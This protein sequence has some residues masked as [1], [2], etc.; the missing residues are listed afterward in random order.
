MPRLHQHF[1]LVA[2][3]G[4]GGVGTVWRARDLRSGEAVALKVLHPHLRGDTLVAE[5]FRREAALGQSLRHPNVTRAFELFEDAEALSF[6][7]ELLEG[8]TLKEAILAGGPLSV[9]EAVRVAR[10][11]LLGLGAAHAAGIIHRD[12]KPQNVFVCANGEVKLLDFGFARVASAAG[13]TTRSL[14]LCTPDYAA[15]ETVMARPVDGRADLYALGVVLYEALTGRLPFRGGTPFDLLRRHLEEPPPSPRSLRPEL[16]RSLD[17][18][19]LRLM[20]KAPQERYATCEAV[21]DA[22]TAQAHALPTPGTTCPT[23]QAPRDARW[24]LCPACGTTE[25]GHAAGDW[26]VVLTRAPVAA[27]P[28]L[29]RLLDGVGAQARWGLKRRDKKVV[30]GLPKV[31]LKGIGEPL[32]RLVR[33]RAIAGDLQVEMRR[34]S[35]NN[36]DLL[37]DSNTPGYLFLLGVMLPWMGVLGWAITSLVESGHGLP[38]VVAVGFGGPALAAV[39]MRYPHQVLPALASLQKLAPTAQLPPRLVARYRDALPRLTE[40]SLRGTLARLFERALVV[41][42]TASQGQAHVQML[43]DDTARATL[44]VAERAVALALEAQDALDRLQRADEPGLV[45]DLEVLRSRLAQSPADP[46]LVTALAAREQALA[47]T[48]ALE[49][50]HLQASHR[51]LRAATALEVTAVQVLLAHAQDGAGISVQLQQVL[52]EAHF[53]G[54][55]ARRISQDAARDGGLPRAGSVPRATVVKAAP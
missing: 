5:R 37:H 15:P 24:P 18:L 7:L 23:C 44:E 40:P 8:R 36:S 52:D 50:A 1:D 12:F 22:L 33:D 32:A 16:P 42:V 21:L 34:Q 45:Q 10:A 4:S 48:A 28:T 47:E 14:V 13:L 46:A 2:P 55:A 19:V 30:A 54:E 25:Q 20:A 31:I 51:L 43:L 39:V 6:S 49:Q 29:R 3:I 26:M 9:D 53:A 27:V 35:E 41:H 11:C 17:A 38:L